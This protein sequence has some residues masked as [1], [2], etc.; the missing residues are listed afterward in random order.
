MVP[1]SQIQDAGAVD[2]VS[3]AGVDSEH[4][5]CF[6]NAGTTYCVAPIVTNGTIHHSIGGAPRYG[7]FDYFAV[8]VDCCSCPWLKQTRDGLCIRDFLCSKV[9]GHQLP[10]WCM[11]ASLGRRRDP[12]HGFGSETLLPT[13]CG[14]LGQHIPKDFQSSAFL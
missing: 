14:R 2:F 7:S 8:G 13:C 1:G 6:M 9:P 10:M 3:T 12:F 4:G 5:G 11:E